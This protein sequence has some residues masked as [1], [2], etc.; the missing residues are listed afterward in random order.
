MA[1]E[2][3]KDPET[4]FGPFRIK[5]TGV[6]P[7]STHDLPRKMRMGPIQIKSEYRVVS[8]AREHGVSKTAAY[9]A[10]R[11]PYAPSIIGRPVLSPDEFPKQ[12]SPACI[13]DGFFDLS[14]HGLHPSTLCRSL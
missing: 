1:R 7:A 2:L 4:S 13:C 5:S 3:W 6:I 12:R 14:V 9:L 8:D 11:V 10:D